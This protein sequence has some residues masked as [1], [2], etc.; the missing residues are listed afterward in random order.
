[1]RAIIRDSYWKWRN[2][3]NDRLVRFG[4]RYFY[5]YRYPSQLCLWYCVCDR[6]VVYDGLRSNMWR[7]GDA[8]NC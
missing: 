4:S 3:F 1:M 2:T 7:M 8:S 6:D 5:G